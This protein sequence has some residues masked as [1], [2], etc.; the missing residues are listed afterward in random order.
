MSLKFDFGQRLQCLRKVPQIKGLSEQSY[1]VLG[2]AFIRKEFEAGDD[3]IVQGEAGDTMYFV[4]SGCP[5]AI[6]DGLGKVA[7]LVPGSFFGELAC[8]SEAPRTATVRAQEDPDTGASCVVWELS[9]VDVQ[10][11][12]GRDRRA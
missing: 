9:R 5:V 10:L 2:K 3:I 8:V 6:V 4:Q 1:N 12:F 7:D 11:Q